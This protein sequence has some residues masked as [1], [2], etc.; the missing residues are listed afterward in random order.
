MADDVY[1]WG[2]GLSFALLLVA[3]RRAGHERASL[4]AGSLLHVC[5][6]SSSRHLSY[7]GSVYPVAIN[8][9]HIFD[10]WPDK[11]PRKLG[12]YITW[13]AI[14]TTCVTSS[15]FLTA[16]APNLLAVDLIAKNTG[17]AI[18]WGE[19]ASVMLPLMVPLF[20]ITPWLIYVIY[21]PTQK[22]SPE[23]PAW[24][25]EELK[26]LGAI[27]FKEYLM[28]GLATVALVLWIF[29]KEF[30]IDA[31]SISSYSKT[32]SQVQ[33]GHNKE[34]D[35]L[36]Q[37]NLALVFGESSMLPFYYRKL[38]GNIPDSKTVKHLLKELDN[39]G[40]SKVKLVMDRGFYSQENI[41]ALFKAH[42]K[43]LLSASLNLSFIRNNLDKVFNSVRSFENYNDKYELYTTT[44]QTTWEYSE[45][46]VYKQ[47]IAK[48]SKRV[49]IH[50]YFNIEKAAEDEKTFDKKLMILKNEIES[51]NRIKENENLYAKYFIIN[52]TLK[53]GIKVTLKSEEVAKAKRNYGY[54]ALITN[55]NM[56]S[57]TALE[58]YR[59]KDVVEKAFGNLKERLNMRRL[60]VSSEQSLDGKLFVQFIALIYLSYIKK[61]MQQNNLFKNYTLESL[62]DKLDLIECFEY[63]GKTLQVG[64]IL[65]KQKDIY[66]FMGVEP[67]S[68]L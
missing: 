32:L 2:Y 21:P 1:L 16:L 50:Y 40:F 11:E 57:I 66:R 46:R 22:T 13:V 47:D 64:E 48:S 5:R 26:K 6:C 33:Y 44:L 24:A 60:L 55:E 59:N 10:S 17:H 28:A 54:F 68:S 20:L 34:H 27:T 62:L 56:D 25:A 52:S 15:M 29:G 19:W 53:K 31:T 12:A 38:P 3:S 36:A 49:Y 14:A 35:P 65:Q 8:I 41:N 61:Q 37:I 63:P 18:T 67:P 30:G 9:P 51:N 39:L 4:S 42:L 58:T 23:A 43:F 45:S 7:G